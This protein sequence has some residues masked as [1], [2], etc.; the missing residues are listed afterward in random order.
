MLDWLI[1]FF[2]A[3]FRIGTKK[4]PKCGADLQRMG[5][6]DRGK[7]YYCTSCSQVWVKTK[8]GWQ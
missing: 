8:D 7:G 1:D 4:C 2:M 5:T 3:L 6:S